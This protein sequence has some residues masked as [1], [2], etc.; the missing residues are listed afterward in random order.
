VESYKTSLKTI[1]DIMGQVGFR[2]KEGVDLSDKDSI[3]VIISYLSEYFAKKTGVE[4]G[5]LKA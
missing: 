2:D 5:K 4:V 3:S 1:M